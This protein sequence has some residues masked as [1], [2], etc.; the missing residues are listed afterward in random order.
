MFSVFLLLSIPCVSAATCPDCN[1]T[2]EVDCPS[3]GGDGKVTE[4]YT[5]EIVRT[6][7]SGKW[8]LRGFDWKMEITG[9]FYNEDEDGTYATVYAATYR[10]DTVYDEGTKRVWF[11]SEEKT[12]VKF[13]LDVKDDGADW[14]YNIYIK[15]TESVTHEVECS[16]CDGTGKITCSRCD[17]TGQIT[18]SSGGGGSGGINI[19]GFPWEGVLIGII[20]AT[21]V[22]IPR[23]TYHPSAR[24]LKT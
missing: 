14:K 9:E 2:G 17:G 18:T 5:P 24:I 20:L 8:T 3:C 19:P 23:R 22:I 13:V 15:E 11:D 10:Y 16:R 12:E 1:G 6:D 21:A 7:R 4:S